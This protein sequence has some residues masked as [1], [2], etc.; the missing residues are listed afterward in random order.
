[1]ELCPAFNPRMWEDTPSGVQLSI[2]FVSR[3]SSTT[4]NEMSISNTKNFRCHFF[5]NWHSAIFFQCHNFPVPFS[6]PRG[7]TVLELKYRPDP[8]LRLYGVI[9]I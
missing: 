5:P 9:D 2:V 8:Y 7:N 6:V 4:N 1:M 3:T